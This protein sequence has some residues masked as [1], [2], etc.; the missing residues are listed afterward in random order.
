MFINPVLG[1]SK[2]IQARF[3]TRPGTINGIKGI[4]VKKRENGVSVLVV[5]K[6]STVAMDVAIK[7]D[8]KAKDR[9]LIK[10]LKLLGSEKASK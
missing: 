2:Y 8:P 6:A 3:S 1:L 7:A 10:S 5:I 9:L 4:I